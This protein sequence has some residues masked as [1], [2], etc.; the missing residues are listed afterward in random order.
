[1]VDERRTER[2]RGGGE[3]GKFG[4]IG[5][6]GDKIGSDA[7]SSAQ[8]RGGDGGEVLRMG[9]GFGLGCGDI[10]ELAYCVPRVLVCMLT[11]TVHGAGCII[12]CIFGAST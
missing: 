4:S 3:L 12:G 1:M 8:L 2:L 10:C 6:G 11:L 7:A 5:I 9:S